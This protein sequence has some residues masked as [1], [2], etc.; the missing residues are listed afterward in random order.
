MGWCIVL[1]EDKHTPYNAADHW[2]Q[3]L[4]WQHVSVI[5]YLLIVAPRS[6]KMRTAV[7]KLDCTATETLRTAESGTRAQKMS[8]AAEKSDI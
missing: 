4:Q 3:F 1:L 5:Y 8:S 2:R 7:S 6:M